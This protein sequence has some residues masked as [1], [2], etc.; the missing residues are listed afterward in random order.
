MGYIV[1]PF[2]DRTECNP[3]KYQA[4]YIEVIVEPLLYTWC[5]FL[6]ACKHEIITRGLEENKKLIA[7]K[8]DE[9][10]ALGSLNQPIQEQNQGSDDMDVDD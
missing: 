4:G 10:K 5:E 8:I 1:S 9:T 7:I 2:Y 3:F 6:P